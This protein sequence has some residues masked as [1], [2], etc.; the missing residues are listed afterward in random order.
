M[1]LTNLALG[2]RRLSERRKKAGGLRGRER[3]G[4]RGQMAVSGDEE[5]LPEVFIRNEAGFPEG[6]DGGLDVVV[7]DAGEDGF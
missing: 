6:V 1:Y 4:E 7:Q 3:Y 5:V 2:V